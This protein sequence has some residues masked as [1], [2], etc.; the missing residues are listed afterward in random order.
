[1]CLVTCHFDMS[2]PDTQAYYTLVLSKQMAHMHVSLPTCTYNSTHHRVEASLCLAPMRYNMH[3]S[4]QQPH[5]LLQQC[6]ACLALMAVQ[7]KNT[8][9]LHKPC[10][11]QVMQ[12]GT[13]GLRLVQG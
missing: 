7:G 5:R 11:T 1:M 10:L 12:R 3:K 2:Q 13:G 8:L 9:G 4:M 6:I